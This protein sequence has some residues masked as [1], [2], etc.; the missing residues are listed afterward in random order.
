M[1][2][3]MFTYPAPN[4]LKC[5]WKSLES[6]CKHTGGFS[7]FQGVAA[8]SYEHDVFIL[9]QNCSFC[10]SIEIG[11]FNIQSSISKTWSQVAL[12]ERRLT[13]SVGLPFFFKGTVIKSIPRGN[14]VFGH[15]VWHIHSA[16]VY[17]KNLCP[18]QP[19]A[20]CWELYIPE[21]PIKAVRVI[22][23]NEN[24]LSRADRWWSCR[25]RGLPSI[26][27]QLSVF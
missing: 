13:S 1:V 10:Q 23:S 27:T 9:L 17:R 7:F 21:F 24:R 11:V 16:T 18:F 6:Q 15:L 25:R 22:M 26:S 19:N 2:T 12:T 20:S 5:H 14:A 4:A 3:F 8:L